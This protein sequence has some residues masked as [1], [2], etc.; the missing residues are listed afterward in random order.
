MTFES[1][2]EYEEFARFK[3]RY[4]IDI[5]IKFDPE[6]KFEP[7]DVISEELGPLV[8]TPSAP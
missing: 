3:E 4:N 2:S 1:R 8:E 6:T 7:A 5:A